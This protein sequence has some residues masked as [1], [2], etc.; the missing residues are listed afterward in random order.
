[1]I[2]FLAPHWFLLVPV[3]VVA[4]WQWRSLGLTRPLRALCVPCARLQ[5]MKYEVI[6]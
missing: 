4:G 3:L 5:S 1:M 2:R 6:K